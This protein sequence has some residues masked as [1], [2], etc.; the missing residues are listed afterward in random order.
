MEVRSFLFRR[1]LLSPDPQTIFFHSFS[2][3]HNFVNMN[4]SSEYC[5]FISSM[6]VFISPLVLIFYYK[7]LPKTKSNNMG[8]KNKIKY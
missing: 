8:M 6:F 5:Y 1:L 3:S 4:R 7:F 2:K